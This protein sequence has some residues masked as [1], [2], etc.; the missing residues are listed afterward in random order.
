MVS[1]ESVAIL[2]G[3]RLELRQPR[4]PANPAVVVT[5]LGEGLE[6][7]LA[8]GPMA[9]VGQRVVDLVGVSASNRPSRLLTL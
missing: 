8:G 7:F 5:L 3:D 1:P 2:G 4:R 9:V 6:D